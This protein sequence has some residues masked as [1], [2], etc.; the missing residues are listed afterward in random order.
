MTILT[1]ANSKGGGGKTTI[2]ACLK[3]EKNYGNQAFGDSHETTIKAA[4]QISDLATELMPYQAAMGGKEMKVALTAICLTF[5]LSASDAVAGKRAYIGSG[6]TSCG[7]WIAERDQIL[8]ESRKLWILGYLSGQNALSSVDFLSGFEV[9]GISAA[10]DK[11]CRENPLNKA[12]DAADNVAGQ[13]LRM[14]K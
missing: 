9:E 13:M 5:L 4:D 2:A 1:L 8:R 6:A 7:E 11:Y 12:V 10:I 3:V 14:K